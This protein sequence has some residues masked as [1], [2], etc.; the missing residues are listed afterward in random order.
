V[1]FRLRAMAERDLDD[2]LAL[3]D[4]S[5]EAPR[6]TRRDYELILLSAPSD[7]LARCGMVALSGARLAGFALITWL[8]LETAAEIEGLVVDRDNRRHGIGAALT[9]A[10]MA[11]AASIGAA[12]V[13]LEVRSSNAAAIA[14]YH[15]HGFSPVGRR[16]AYYSDPVED[17]L[18]FE[19]EL[20]P[21]PEP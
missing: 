11:W 6:W 2:V 14:L 5:V 7:P 21:H 15:R 8:R 17:A 1:S 4:A 18:L 10:C 9:G 12:T 20:L 13:R 19:A 16:R 3:V